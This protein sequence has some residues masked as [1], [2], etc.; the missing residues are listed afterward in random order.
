MAK[1]SVV[2]PI[3]NAEKYLNKCINSLVHQT[4]KDIEIIFVA[5]GSEDLCSD[6]ISSYAD[7]RITLL[8]QSNSNAGCARNKGMEHAAGEY[9]IFLDANDYFELDMLELMYNK[10]LAD[11]ADICIC[12]AESF[13]DEAG[14]TCE[15]DFHLDTSVVSQKLP[16]SAE[17]VKDRVFN[18]TSSVPWNKLFKTKFI[19][20]NGLLF[21]SVKKTDDL[22]FVFANLALAKRITYVNKPFVHHLFCNE[23]QG[24]KNAL[25]LAFYDAVIALKNE[26]ECRNLLKTYDKSFVNMA[27]SVCAYTFYGV[28]DKKNFAELASFLKSKCFYDF[29]IAGHTR[30]Y[31]YNKSDFDVFLDVINLDESSLWRKYHEMP[32]DEAYPLIDIDNWQCPV[33]IPQDGKIKISV[34]VPVY[35]AEDYVAQCV[36]SIRNNTLKDIEIICVNDG[37]TDNSLAVLN[38]LKKQ[39]NRIIV[40]DKP[41]GGPSQTRNKGLEIA[42]GEYISFIDSDD[43]IHPRTYEFLYAEAEKD[44]LDQLYFSAASFFV[45]DDIYHDYSAFDTLY[46]RKKDYSGIFT[47]KEM[48]IKMVQNGEFRPSP[49]LLLSRRDF[50]EK[51]NLR[52]CNGILHEDNLFIIQCLTFAEKVRF[53][54]INLY[55]RRVRFNSIM[56]GNHALKRIYSY[57]RI[58]KI[59]EQF[60]KENH[61]KKDKEFFNALM[62]QLS[63]M[64]YSACD[65]AEKITQEELN[66]FVE[67]LDEA[68]AID[69]YN[70]IHAVARIRV[71]NKE[72]A[73][74]AKASSELAR[75]TDY[76]FRQQNKRL[77]D[78]NKK[79]ILEKDALENEN[80]LLKSK[81]ALKLVRLALKLDAFLAKIKGKK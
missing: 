15:S 7:E 56:T 30:G 3:S 65:I 60:A 31:F 9:I 37:S 19:K 33:D 61:L 34:I 24:E 28:K 64:D 45:S 27:L 71:K 36:D 69:F 42:Q 59:L 58:I 40:V 66:Q 17:D 14:E 13:N 80:E 44:N 77:E 47:G 67:T 20:E 50:Y 39:D 74:K 72:L 43:Y 76:K 41:N 63:V 62:F 18:F 25:N 26:L 8:T 79:L 49:C 81:L 57:Y 4:L 75:I 78:A 11:D 52:F 38:E 70:H 68:Q 55:Y 16:F 48:F 2:V 51:N 54:N 23:L 35:N 22:F 73:K 12:N 6:I 32:A 1:V 21:Q 5:N 29:G 10:A 53:A 46:R